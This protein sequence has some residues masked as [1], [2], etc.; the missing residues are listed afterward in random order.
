MKQLG[1]RKILGI[2]PGTAVTGF[3]I[4]EKNNRTIDV[5]DYGCI[6]P[7]KNLDISKRYLI[8]F[9]NIDLLIK[10]YKPDVMAIETQFV[11]KNAK[12]A[13]TLGMAK[14]AALIAA[15]KNE[16]EVFEYAPKKAKLSVVGTGNA[17]KHQV[18]KMIQMLLNLS[19][20]PTP[21]D[22]ADALALAL[23]HAHQTNLKG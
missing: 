21:E 18:Q 11:Y 14:G 13:L 20:P 1:N 17:S 15:A 19:K 12:A 10:K 5:V 8:I 22:A 4:I 7:P 6:K 3:G 23:C 16:V 2:D 9:E